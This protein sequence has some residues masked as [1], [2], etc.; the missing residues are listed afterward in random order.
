MVAEVSGSARIFDKLGAAEMQHAV[1]RCLHRMECVAAGFK[2]QVREAIGEAR[3][4]AVF[5]SAEIAHLAASEMQQRVLDLPP[6][7]GIKLA[8]K[9]SFPPVSAIGDTATPTA[10]LSLRHGGVV[11]ALGSDKA[12]AALGRDPNSDIV[13]KNPRASRNHARIEQRRESYVLIDQS[14]NGTFVSFAGSPEIVL[15]REEVILHG[16]GYISCGSAYGPESG[17][18]VEFDCT[19]VEGQ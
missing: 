12:E 11:I 4:M 19:T 2:G 1:L 3:L 14:S 10:Y 7:S 16:R 5:E 17:E 8:V 9:I 15:K 18:L 13:I 6:M